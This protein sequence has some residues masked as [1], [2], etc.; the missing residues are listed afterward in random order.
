MLQH[1]LQL[2]Q[3]AYYAIFAP[4]LVTVT[5]R[6]FAT[7]IATATPYDIVGKVYY[8]TPANVLD[9]EAALCYF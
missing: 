7:T 2:I 6:G 1:S 3:L 9:R 5:L 4:I 8:K